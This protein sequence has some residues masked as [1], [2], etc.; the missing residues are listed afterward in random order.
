M[1]KAQVK[2]LVAVAVETNA[3]MA[4]DQHTIVSVVRA[5]HSPGRK[6]QRWQKQNW[7]SASSDLGRATASILKKC[8]LPQP[9]VA[10]S[11]ILD[12]NFGL[13]DDGPYGV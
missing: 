12:C 7:F 5:W 2:F 1:C 6:F 13:C 4:G 3:H 10:L 9:M 11:Q 8:H